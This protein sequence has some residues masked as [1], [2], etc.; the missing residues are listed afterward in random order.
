MKEKM[1]VIIR[2]VIITII[3]SA[4]FVIAGDF[5]IKNTGVK[6]ASLIIYGDTIASGYNPFVEDSKV[7]LSVDTVKKFIDEDLFFDSASEK[8]IITTEDE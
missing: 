3:I 4:L 2:T 5:K 7:Y 1:V 6:E 8:V